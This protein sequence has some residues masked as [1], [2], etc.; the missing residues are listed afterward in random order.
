ML[1]Y[2]VSLSPDGAVTSPIAASPR[3]SRVAV[4]VSPAVRLMPTLVSTTPGSCD[5]SRILLDLLV[6]ANPV[7]I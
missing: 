5:C 6:A 4:G 1:P 2:T 3:T 7:L